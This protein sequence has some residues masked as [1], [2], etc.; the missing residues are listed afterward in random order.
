MRSGL[1][2]ILI[3][4]GSGCRFVWLRGTI[5][6]NFGRGCYDE[7]LYEIVLNLD[8]QIS[9]RCHLKTFLIYSSGGPFVWR[10]RTKPCV[11]FW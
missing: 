7:H 1:K 3:H 11:Q 8:Q 9:S 10:S 4:S 6:C 5:L 2:I